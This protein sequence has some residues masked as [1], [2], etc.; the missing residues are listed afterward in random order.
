MISNPWDGAAIEIIQPLT[1][2]CSE[3]DASLASFSASPSGT[4][5]LLTI[6]LLGPGD[7][8]VNGS[9]E[10]ISIA[11]NVT[12][13]EII[14]LDGT[15]VATAGVPFANNVIVPVSY[16]GTISSG[17][18]TVELRYFTASTGIGVDQLAAITL[19]T[20]VCSS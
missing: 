19:S 10:T 1:N 2:P 7:L 17:V 9:L 5:T 4:F 8:T 11:E 14:N 16:E 15:D 3:Q 20:A 18:H 12:H 6:T 13:T